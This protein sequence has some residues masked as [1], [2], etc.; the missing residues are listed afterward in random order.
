MGLYKGIQNLETTHLTVEWESSLIM[1]LTYLQL[2]FSVAHFPSMITV[3]T[4]KTLKY[5]IKDCD[6]PVK[7]KSITTYKPEFPTQSYKSI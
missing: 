1:A 2:T 3:E 7:I 6:N 4:N 5:K